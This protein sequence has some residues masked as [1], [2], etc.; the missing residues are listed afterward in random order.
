[1]VVST[2]V[3]IGFGIFIYVLVHKEKKGNPLFAPLMAA[4]GEDATRDKDLFSMAG[5]GMV[6]GGMSD[7]A[8]IQMEMQGIAG[9]SST[10]G[11]LDSDIDL[12]PA[13]PPPPI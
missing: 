4:M 13:L 5:N 10:T 6:V 11:H 3:A 8:A 1:M 12:E 7:N 9:R 2:V